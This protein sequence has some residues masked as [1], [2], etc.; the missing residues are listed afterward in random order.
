MDKRAQIGGLPNGATTYS[1]K[2][3]SEVASLSR[4][5]RAPASL[6]E[7]PCAN[8]SA[9][10]HGVRKFRNE[11]PN[12]VKPSPPG[13][14]LGGGQRS[15]SETQARSQARSVRRPE[16][17]SELTTTP[18]KSEYTL[19]H[20]TLTKISPGNVNNS[21]PQKGRR[22]DHHLPDQMERQRV[23]SVL[24]PIAGRS[25]SWQPTR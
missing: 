11:R 19:P 5:E 8:A 4:R 18:I 16:E 22:R 24:A 2:P 10:S 21:V 3:A 12:V 13:A 20:K 9:R 23:H 6:Y 15:M 25:P 1:V 14:A 17:W 7:V